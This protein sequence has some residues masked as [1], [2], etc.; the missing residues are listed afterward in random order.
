MTCGNCSVVGHNRRRC[1]LLQ[2]GKQVLPDMPVSAP[3]PSEENEPVFTPTPGFV[4]FS[5]RQTSHQSSEA[6][7]KAHGPLKS[8]SKNVSK[9]K[10][11]AVPKRSKNS[12]KEKVIALQFQLLMKMK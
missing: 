9:D 6:F 11:D 8:K 1:H 5:S 7:N 4:V 2:K 10:V 3:K 12:V